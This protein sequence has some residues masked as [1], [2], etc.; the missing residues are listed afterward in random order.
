MKKVIIVAA[1]LV[2]AGI[3]VWAGAKKNN[4]NNKPALQEPIASTS[5]P[6]LK[7]TATSTA[8]STK[9]A[10]PA[11]TIKDIAWRTFEKYL[12]AVKAHD[13]EKVKALSH[14]QSEQCANPDRKE[15]CF[16]MMDTVYNIGRLIKKEEL[17]NVWSDKKQIILS[18]NYRPFRDEKV[19]GMDRSVIYFTIVGGEYKILNY[20]PA[21]GYYVPHDGK[22]SSDQQLQSEIKA[23][24]ID[25]D[26][27]GVTDYEENCAGQFSGNPFCKKT[28][29]QDRDSD[30]D[31]WWD[32]IEY[33]FYKKD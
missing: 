6:V 2:I 4:E 1:A 22:L 12:E 33:F 27:D 21:E 3:I 29:P 9:K 15:E 30:N 31:L 23:S 16:K 25:T 11:P 18:S 32:G 14:Q 17:V 24:V 13:I 20:N 10:A 28:D 26:K 7:E 8:T 19:E 5:T